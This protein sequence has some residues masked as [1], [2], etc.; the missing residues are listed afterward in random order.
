MNGKRTPWAYY[1]D[2]TLENARIDLLDAKAKVKG[3]V[4]PTDEKRRERLAKLISSENSFQSVAEEWL[5]K[6]IKWA[7]SHRKKVVLRL[8]NDAYPIIGKRPI[9]E[10]KSP[11]VL[12]MLRKVESRGVIDS[13]H[14]IKQSVSQIFRFGVATGRCESDP[15]TSLKGAL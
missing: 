2:L 10:I 14:R 3:G 7:D 12:A 9:A 4:D 13:A 11:E 6:Q 15:T 8:E 5:T 1:P